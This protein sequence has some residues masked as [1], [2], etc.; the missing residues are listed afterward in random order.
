MKWARRVVR[1]V[2]HPAPG[3]PLQAVL[4]MGIVV[5]FWLVVPSG[6][7]L[8]CETDQEIVLIKNTPLG[9]ETSLDASW[10]SNPDQAQGD[11]FWL[12]P[13]PSLQGEGPNAFLQEG[14]N[15]IT[16][17]SWQGDAGLS[18]QTARVNVT[19]AFDIT[20][21][22]LKKKVSITWKRVNG[23][24]RYEVYR[25]RGGDGAR[26][27][28]VASLKATSFSFADTGLGDETYLYTVGA[29]VGAEWRFSRIRA[30]HPWGWGSG[31]NDAPVIYSLPVSCATSGIP[32]TYDV[33]AADAN[34]DT[35]SYVL[36]KPPSGMVIDRSSGLIT[37]TPSSAGDYEIVVKAKD[38]KGLCSIQTF[39][40]EVDEALAPN[41]KPRADAGGPYEAAVGQSIA[42]DGSRS[43]D[44]DGDEL[45]F[46]W[47]FGDGTGGFGPRPSHTYASQGVYAVRLV[48]ADGKGAS[49]EAL[50]SATVRECVAPTVVFE[51]SP[52][53]VMTG[54]PCTLMWSAI[55]ATHVSIDHGVGPVALAGTFTVYPVQSTTYT[56]IS[57][58]PC[59]TATKSVTVMVA[60][61]PEVNLE[62]SPALVVKGQSSTLSWVSTGASTVEIDHGIGGVPASGSVVVTPEATTNYTATASGPGGTATDSATVTVIEPPRVSMTAQPGTIIQG[63]SSMLTW[64]SENADTA[65]LDNGIGNVGLSGIF[66]VRPEETTAYTITVQGPGGSAWATAVVEVIPRPSVV[67]TAE[68][69]PIDAGQMTVLRWSSAHADAASLDNGIGAVPVQGWMEIAPPETTTYTITATGPGGTAVASVTVQVNAAAPV[70]KA[71]AYITNQGSNDVTVIDVAANRVTSRIGS[72]EIPY[73]V[74]VSPDGKRVYITTYDGIQV[75][76]TLTDGIAAVIP[77]H[78]DTVAASPDGKLIYAVSAEE[79][80][81]TAIDASTYDVLGS[82]R[83]GSMPRAIAVT[84]DA[85]K[86]YVGDLSDGAVRVFDGR[87]LK[88]K[89]TVEGMNPWGSVCDLEVS[90]DGKRL[91]AATDSSCTLFLIDTSTDRVVNSR[92]YLI[93]RTVDDVYLSVSP[94][95]QRLFMSYLKGG[96]RVLCLDPTSLDILGE[97]EMGCPSDMSF[98]PDGAFLYVPDALEDSVT[99]LDTGSCS[100]S[101]VLTGAFAEPYTCGHFVAETRE[102][103]D[104]RVS[105][106]GQGV[107]G[108]WVVLEGEGVRK[109]FRTDAQGMY[110][111]YVRPG[112]YS[113]RFDQAGFVFSREALDVFVSDK[114]VHVDDVEVLLGGR[115]Q[116]E[117]ESISRGETSVLVWET[118]G[119]A[120]VTI[121]PGMGSLGPSGS[122][123]VT[124]SGTTT[125]VLTAS[126]ARGTV[127]TSCATVTVF[128][129]PEVF[130]EA[131]PV[132]VARGGSTTL[133]WSCTGADEV[134]LE[135][136]GWSVDAAGRYTLVP[137]A[138]TTYTIVARGPGGTSSAS[139]TVTVHMPPE[140]S[141]IVDPRAIF[142]GEQ[143]TLSWTT[144]GA[145]EI[146]IDGGIGQVA[147]IGSVIVSP[148]VTT[149]YTITARGKGGVSIASVTL[150]VRNV[151]QVTVDSPAP[152]SIIQRPDVLVFGSVSHARGLETGVTVNGVPVPVCGGLFVANHVPLSPGVNRIVVRAR[153]M[154]GNEGAVEVNVVCDSNGPYVTLKVDEP[155]GVCAHETRLRLDSALTI[156]AMTVEDTGDGLVSYTPAESP[157]EQN[158]RIDGKGVFFITASTSVG[159]SMC[160]DT[161]GIVVY[162]R[163]ELDGLLRQKWGMMLDGL[164]KGDV[165]A[166]VKDFTPRTKDVF[167]KA[168]GYLSAER[169]ASLARELEDIRFIRMAGS[170]A[171]YDI[172]I[173][174]DGTVFS[175]CLLFEMDEDGIWKIGRF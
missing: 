57:E 31:P 68:P 44:P 27:E 129:P 159:G 172:R 138:T 161:V 90:P 92:Y 126:D 121:E 151:I 115:L 169:R 66:E 163:D 96:G 40:I 116:A 107:E 77:V 98:T 8:A 135:P 111:F 127:V 24:S 26:F 2:V 50:T 119:A 69:N 153:D 48:V 80:T 25:A 93:E 162:D 60:E 32:Y 41:R 76:D 171:E 152:G 29:L 95:G 154:L 139:V 9:V 14:Y 145:E 62:A 37:W 85:H 168:F 130:L 133:S 75:I 117:P 120:S 166:A 144:L 173:E 36:V 64:A 59:G 35:I 5:F 164:G 147:P 106:G 63:Q 42:F 124:P 20:V 38:V 91:Y 81:L 3:F 33:N 78:A 155:V 143:A 122:A 113:L 43:F 13:C 84:P 73:G 175:Y 114:L 28:K 132:D 110:F 123:E 22:P 72:G 53:A 102:R 12:G 99:V 128:S 118:F 167:K 7:I 45:S 156:E 89:G 46:L 4:W 160:S 157:L 51:A 134:W 87:D 131:D 6:R 104:G 165:D 97:V 105:F 82:V 19:A 56:I 11:L 146:T 103:I 23:A 17:L 67:I 49:D 148:S 18:M 54:Q 55:N 109:V 125:Y 1:V 86:I 52:W 112:R 71:G 70:R 30:V 79:G 136:M 149:T 58:G 108:V 34:G 100:P 137:P 39:I 170:S 83:A 21:V 158:V 142:T 174:R 74:D 61:P 101:S 47:D 150:E 88:E 141:I 65:F 94:N 140:V 16:L 15:A 10:F